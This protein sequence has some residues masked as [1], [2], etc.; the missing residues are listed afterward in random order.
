MNTSTPNSFLTRREEADLGSPIEECSESSER[1]DDSG[2]ATGNKTTE[3]SDKVDQAELTPPKVEP[4]VV[5]IAR[6]IIGGN[7]HQ[8]S[9]EDFTRRRSM[10][11]PTRNNAYVIKGGI[12]KLEDVRR[13]KIDSDG[14]D[15]DLWDKQ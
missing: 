4:K 3:L 14:M 12:L 10:S 5:V 7:E 9:F 15:L 8:S 6:N 13:I 2:S 1:S 11:F